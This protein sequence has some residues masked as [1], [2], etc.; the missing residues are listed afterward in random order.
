MK[1][2]AASYKYGTGGLESWFLKHRLQRDTAC[3]DE[4]HIIPST[5]T[6]HDGPRCLH[7]DTGS[8]LDSCC[9][10]PVFKFFV[11]RKKEMPATKK[12]NFSKTISFPLPTPPHRL[13]STAPQKFQPKFIHTA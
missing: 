7:L 9:F 6:E 12:H 4:N 10:C 1:F 8:A 11:L 5:V 3:I 13:I 2:A